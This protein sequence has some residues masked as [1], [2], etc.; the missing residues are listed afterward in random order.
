MPK[1]K[2]IAEW[3]WPVGLGLVLVGGVTLFVLN[4]GP[5]PAVA[6]GARPAAVGK[7]GSMIQ[8]IEVANVVAE[9]RGWYTVPAGRAGLE[10]QAAPGTVVRIS[11]WRDTEPEPQHDASTTVWEWPDLEAARQ[12]PDGSWTIDWPL[13]AGERS[14]AYVFA[15]GRDDALE[16]SGQ[17]NIQAA[18]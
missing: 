1:P 14:H 16:Q 2:T 11:H 12:Q 9:H 6:P 5:Q 15:I 4:W 17:Y 8:S 13:A 10:V 18:P 3:V 7:P